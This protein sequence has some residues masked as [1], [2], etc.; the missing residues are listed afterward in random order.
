MDVH[1]NFR[2]VIKMMI[3]NL[4]SISNLY[5]ATQTRSTSRSNAASRTQN[6]DEFVISQTGQDFKTLLNKLKNTSDV[7]EDRVSQ[8]SAQ[9]EAGTYHVSADDIAASILNSRF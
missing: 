4:H 9:I 3:N 6:R 5:S 2:W 7:R 8:L 1:A